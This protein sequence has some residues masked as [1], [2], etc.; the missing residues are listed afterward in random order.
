MYL[1]SVFFS[2]LRLIAVGMRV[3]IFVAFCAVI[4]MGCG[5]SKPIK[6]EFRIIPFGRYS[7]KFGDLNDKHLAAAKSIGIKPVVSRKEAERLGRKLREIETCKYYTVDK[8]THSIPFLVP[9]A[10]DLLETIGENF[11]DSVKSKGASGYKI[12]VT[13]V[14]RP[15]EDVKNLR[16][17]NGNASSNSAHRYGTTF[18]IAYTRFDHIDDKYEVPEA[19]LKHALAEVLLALKKAN[20]CYVKYEVKQGCFHITA[21]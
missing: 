18:D 16:R 21:R 10:E 14:L 11:I 19:H 15:E 9:K 3:L 17:R 4:V 8:L 1:K 2:K 7:A 13:S 5:D 6:K 20:K 12:I